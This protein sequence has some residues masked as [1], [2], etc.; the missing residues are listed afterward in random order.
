MKIRKHKFLLHR[1][2]YNILNEPLN[3]RHV[4]KNMFVCLADL[5]LYQYGWEEALADWQWFP[6]ALSVVLVNFRRGAGLAS[7]AFTCGAI[8]IQ[9]IEYAQMHSAA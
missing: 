9:F 6:I 3:S 5:A 8:G 2:P 4:L 1:I 7:L